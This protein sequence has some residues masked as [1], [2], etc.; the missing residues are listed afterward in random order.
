MIL[1][2]QRSR[3]HSVRVRLRSISERPS[4]FIVCVTLYNS[5]RT[6]MLHKIPDLSPPSKRDVSHSLQYKRYS[7]LSSEVTRT[8]SI[9]SASSTLPKK[10]VQTHKHAGCDSPEPN[11]N[12]CVKTPGNDSFMPH[13]PSTSHIAFLLAGLCMQFLPKKLTGAIVCVIILLAIYKSKQISP[14]LSPVSN[15][16]SS[17]AKLVLDSKASYKPIRPQERLKLKK[18]I[19]EDYAFRPYG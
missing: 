11:Y 14:S 12:N 10:D 9:D 17:S 19:D 6:W 5:A 3:G 4:T 15:N 18:S 7:Q 2:S 1:L 16:K 8:N 13:L